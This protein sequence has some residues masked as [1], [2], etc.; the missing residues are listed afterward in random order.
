MKS[1][2]FCSSQRFK[3]DMYEFIAALR[4]LAKEKGMHPVIFD[5]E[6]EDRPDDLHLKS[7]KERMSDYSYRTSVAGRVYDHL[8]RKVRV[9]D[10]CF[11]FNK[12]GYLGA[13]TNGEL[14]AAAALGKTIYALH[15][16]TAMG[17]YPRDL[18]D[19]PSSRKLI[20]E[21]VS[22]PDELLKRLA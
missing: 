15:E 1:V 19:E 14:F 22:T 21:I 9:A 20:H 3:K 7:E 6:F 8:F 5:P 13:N 17:S 2:V 16:K 12:D 10:V 18:Y 11:I 4:N